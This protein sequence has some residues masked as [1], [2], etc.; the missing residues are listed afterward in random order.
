MK[1]LVQGIQGMLAIGILFF[2]PSAGAET[3]EE[4]F[5]RGVRSF[6]DGRYDEAAGAFSSLMDRFGVNSPDVLVNMGAAE[7]SLGRPGR[8]LLA[9]HRAMQAA[10]GSVAAD[11]AAI[12]AERVRADLNRSQGEHPEKDGFVFGR[13]HDAWSATLGWLNPEAA[14]AVFLGFW[15]LLFGSLG[16]RRLTERRRFARLLSG[17]AVAAAVAAI[18]TGIA[19]FGA[20]RVS[21]YRVGVVLDQDTALYGDPASLEESMILPEGLEA[22]ILDN[23]GGFARVRLSSGREGF[24]SAGSMGFP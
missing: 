18:L 12:N 6:E 8:A 15:T 7:F 17:V 23:R 21:G 22:R 10:P 2:T 24:V 11:T 1:S 4:M 14:V 19:A 5:S 3:V 9:F 13:Y 20:V 16:L